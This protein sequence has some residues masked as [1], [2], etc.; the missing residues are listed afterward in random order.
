MCE[1]RLRFEKVAT[2]RVENILKTLDLLS[3]CSN[4]YNYKYEQDDID[5]IFKAINN[6]VKLTH[7]SFVKNIDNNK[8]EL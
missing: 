4:V 8:F 6:K 3:N 5:K 1:K 7:S 2:K